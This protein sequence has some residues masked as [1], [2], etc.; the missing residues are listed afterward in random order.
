M[1]VKSIKEILEG[2]EISNFSGSEATRSLVERE[3][4]SRWGE[5]ELK[6]FDPLRSVLT[7]KTWIQKHNMIPKKGEKAIRSFI[8]VETRD[9]KDPKKVIKKIKSIYL[10][11]FKQVTELTK[12]SV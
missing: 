3:I 12:K 5:Q 4:C 9:K 1:S 6:F 2:P 8:V 11:Y 7:C 10:F